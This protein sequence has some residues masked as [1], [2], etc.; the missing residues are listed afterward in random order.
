M[1]SKA[2]NRAQA[3]LAP[4]LFFCA[5]AAFCQ[6]APP[7]PSMDH[8]LSLQE[9][10]RIAVEQNPSAAAALHSGRSALARI[11]S[12]K[13]A[14][15]PTLDLAGSLQ[16]S[17]AESQGGTGR[18]GLLF[19]AATSTSTDASLSAQYTLWDSGARKAAVGEAS[20]S[21]QS[22]DA[23]YLATAQDLA[24][25]VQTAYFNL[26]GAQWA[27]QVSRDTLKQADFH[28]DLAQARNDVGLAPRSDVLKA[29][30]AQ[31]D[32][33]LQVIQAES[34]VAT[35]R[36]NLCVLMG[37]AADLPL[38]IL[39]A[40]RDAVLPALPE[41]MPAWERAKAVLPEL[42]ASAQS[43]ESFRF[44][45]LS[46]KAAY[47]PTVDLSGNAGLFDTGNWPDRQEW[48]AGV[49]IRIPI[50]TG[51]ARK[52]QIIQARESWES[53]KLNYQTALL[54][55]ESKAYSARIALNEAIQS[56]GAAK[57]YLASAQE[58][59]DVAEGQYQNGLG[60]ML[61]VVD[62]ATAL[63]SAKLRLI[64]ARLS[65]ATARASWDR[66]TGVDML[67]GAQL[68]S[69]GNQGPEGDVKP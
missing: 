40:P 28:L 54:S 63:S 17:Y 51:F 55:A 12:S 49:V 50:F 4:A 31:A 33:R 3:L 52:Y 32:A 60:S 36:S 13:A 68:A 23:Q 42:R 5:G 7:S 2:R 29:A 35:T 47:L 45:Y 37:L 18:K 46:A 14:Y 66:A 56:V 44:G 65:V 25:S 58:N 22:S 34:L 62:A 6:T 64:Q 27:L 11:G 57:A 20:A 39:E 41:W 48:S 59:S 69:T 43:T 30:T 53:A 24:L 61:D 1:T 10:V 38:Q 15:Y 9:C 16:R 26:Q 67:E 19:T 8:P 21:Y